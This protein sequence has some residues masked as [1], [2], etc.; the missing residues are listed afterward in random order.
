[1]GLARRGLLRGA[2][3]QAVLLEAERNIQAKLGPGLLANYHELLVETPLLVAPIPRL[4][5]AEDW[6]REVNEKDAHVVSAA[7]AIDAAYLISLDRQLNAQVNRSGLALHA[8]TPGDFI[9]LI[10]PQ[11]TEFPRMRD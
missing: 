3:S 11:H 8:A 2:V 5:G 10:L 6:L 9:K 1:M 7:T 4:T